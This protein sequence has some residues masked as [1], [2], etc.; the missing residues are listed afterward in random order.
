MGIERD[1]LM[2][3]LMMLFEV[4]HKILRHRKKGENEEA[5]KEIQYFYECLKIDDDIHQLSIEKFI[6]VLVS[7]KKL[8][9]EHLEMVAFVM[10]EQGE[11]AETKKK[12]LNYFNKAYFLLN[13]VEMES[14][15]FS[16]DRQMKLAE[17][18]ESLPD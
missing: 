14:T 12:K 15:S 5:E 1:Y 3:Q 17:L 18:R 2:R 7:Q 11:M 6:D 16:M 4:I 10:K 8:T 9:N 13:K